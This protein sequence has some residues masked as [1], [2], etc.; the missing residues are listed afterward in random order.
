MNR[1]ALS[2]GGLATVTLL[3][4]LMA[5]LGRDPKHIDSPL[6]GKPAPQFTLQRAGSGESIDLAAFRGKPIVVNFWATWCGPCWEEHPILN[7]AARA[8]GD[9]V[10]FLGVVFQDDEAKILGFL[11]QR[12]AA[13]PTVIDQ[14]GTT[15]IAYGVGGVPETFILDANGIIV[16]KHDGPVSAE[17][18]QS[19]LAEVLPR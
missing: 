4:V 19:Y 2:I 12:G 10:Q 17:Q 15:A 14:R 16:A 1:F 6:I 13:Y 11:Q 18:L 3:I 9:R 8:N 5:G 7:E